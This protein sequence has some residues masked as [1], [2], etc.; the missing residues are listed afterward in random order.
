MEKTYYHSNKKPGFFEIELHLKCKA[1]HHDAKFCTDRYGQTVQNQSL[2]FKGEQ[3]DQ[4]VHCLQ[5]H[6]YSLQGLSQLVGPF[7][8]KNVLEHIS[9]ILDWFNVQFNHML[10]TKE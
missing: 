9:R 4:A 5:Y 2:Q 10:S 1:Y 3:F 7:H 6:L 8:N